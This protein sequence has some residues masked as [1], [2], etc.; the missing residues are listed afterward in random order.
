MVFA[1]TDENRV[2]GKTRL[3]RVSFTCGIFCD[4]IF[5]LF[6]AEEDEGMLANSTAS[7]PHTTSSILTPASTSRTD[8]VMYVAIVFSEP[9]HLF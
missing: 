4:C 3:E 9:M 2:G 1:D 8:F 5:I 7:Q 6:Q